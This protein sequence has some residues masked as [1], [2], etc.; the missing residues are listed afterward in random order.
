MK[1]FHETCGDHLDYKKSLARLKLSFT[2]PTIAADVRKLCETCD[3]CQ[4][5]RRCTC[6]D[7]TP[8]SPLPCNEAV[9]DSWVI[10]CLGLLFCQIQLLSCVV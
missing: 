4:K 8:I 5:R 10:N 9:F 7:R 1:L 2:S 6:Y 3:I